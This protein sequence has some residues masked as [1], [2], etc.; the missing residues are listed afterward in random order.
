MTLFLEWTNPD[1]KGF[2]VLGYGLTIAKT[3]AAMIRLNSMLL[4]FAVL[5]NTISWC[6]LPLIR[7]STQRIDTGIP[8]F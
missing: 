3:G 6:A 2:S 5:K 4:M 7:I 1:K 8:L